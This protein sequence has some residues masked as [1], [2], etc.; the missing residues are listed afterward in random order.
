M[1]LKLFGGAS[2]E[3]PG[4]PLA[5]KG[6]QRRRLGLLA[7]LVV[8][9]GRGMSR[10]RI[11]AFLWPE[12]DTDR[13][14]HL[15]SDSIYRIN[16]TFGFDVIVA[17]GDEL[18]LTPGV[19]ESDV[20]CFS[21]AIDRQDWLEATRRYTGPLLDGVFLADSPGFERWVDTERARLAADQARALEALAVAAEARGDPA[22]AVSWWKKLAVHDPLNARVAVR[23][24]QVLDAVGER[25]AA[26]QFARVFDRRVEAELGIV[27]DHSV[28]DLAERFLRE[29]AKRMGQDPAIDPPSPLTSS[30]LPAPADPATVPP[31]PVSPS[32]A[33][34]MAP[35]Y[36]GRLRWILSG[37]AIMAIGI[38][39]LG[40][41]RRPPPPANPSVG[42]I[43][44]LP[45]AD[46]SPDRDQE[47][48]GDGISEELISRLAKVP[49]FRVVSRTSAFAFKGRQL[50][51]REIGVQLGVETVIEGSVRRMDGA[52]RV[53]AQ[54]IEVG[55]GYHLWS[56]TYERGAEE[57]MAVE[58]EIAQAITAT[59]RRGLPAPGEPIAFRAPDIDAETYNLYLQGRYRWHRR[60]EADLGA[61]ADL[62][63]RAIAR[64]PR[65]APAHVGLG[66]AL[67]VMG[68]YDY[69]APAE[70]FPEARRVAETA[71]RLDPA[72]SG[73]HATLGYVALYHEWDWARAEA[74][75]RRAIALDPSYSTAHQWYA[76]LL[77]AMGRFPE[78]EAE[79]RL[80]TELDPLS[81]IA[82][83]ALG[84]VLLH[85]GRY[86]DAIAQCRRTLDLDSTFALAH[87]WKG[88]AENLAGR[89]EAALEALEQ[90]VEFSA[91]S[92]VS[93]AALARVQ[94]ALGRPDLAHDLR[95]ELDGSHYTS[96]YEVAKI[97]VA[98]GDN[99]QA[100]ESLKQ[101]LERRSHSTVFLR[102]DPELAPLRGDP[103][104]EALI[105]RAG[106]T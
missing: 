10:E 51:I 6:V 80:A 14:R 23:L 91:R 30:T 76:N 63:R 60:T 72:S 99:P 84:W 16:Q 32:T 20:E 95:R 19:L 28:R 45:F 74:Q 7:L 21:A 27:P 48:L 81:L 52:I 77:T 9:R 93:V 49:G 104:F 44:V 37:A 75:F 96:A 103:E 47:Y 17:V 89:P 57:V 18:R 46:M 86:E 87:L 97:H 13:A 100:L 39:I 42:T 98:S 73:A 82:N 92:A 3:G 38:V 64:S 106:L 67:A 4:G 61:A 71:L 101:A 85:A 59:L 12:A 33:R 40:V 70:A 79:M 31:S 25:A 58:V 11:T 36:R 105:R 78:A 43:A 90:A 35:W 34:M 22:D 2:L 53:T 94:H 26:I 15:L 88:I 102:V 5:G 68:F 62:F 69:V 55:T 29:P 8:N 56:E 65:Y 66:D 24:M 1:Y 41:V 83:A 54:A 50:D